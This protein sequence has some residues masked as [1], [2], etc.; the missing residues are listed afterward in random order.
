M[1]RP[2]GA[3]KATST[4]A[5]PAAATVRQL[6]AAIAAC[7]AELEAQRQP[8]AG[9]VGSVLDRLHRTGVD[10]RR[11]AAEREQ[12]GDDVGRTSKAAERILRSLEATAP[13]ET[14]PENRTIPAGEGDAGRVA[15]DGLHDSAERAH[16]RASNLSEELR[17][18]MLAHDVTKSQLPHL[19][20][21]LLR[22]RDDKNG[23]ERELVALRRS[24]SELRRKTRREARRVARLASR[25]GQLQ[26]E[27]FPSVAWRPAGSETAAA[28]P[29]DR[30]PRRPL[31]L[32]L[33]GDIRA[34][35]GI[36]EELRQHA[37]DIADLFDP[38]YYLAQYPDVARAG[39]N[40]LLQYVSQGWQ[41]R[42]RPQLL[43]D[44]DYYEAEAGPITGDPLL[45]Y[46]TRAAGR[47]HPLFDP[48]YYLRTYPDVTQSGVDPLLHY[49]RFGA[50]E[51]RRPSPLFDPEYF[52]AQYDLPVDC[53]DALAAYLTQTDGWTAEPHPL[54]SASWFAARAGIERF[55]EAPLA[56]YQKR[57][58]L[59]A[60]APPHPLV[61]VAR[62]RGQS[63]PLR[64]GRSPLEIF[65]DAD[66][67]SDIDAHILFDARLYRYQVE[68]ER[69]R[70]LDEPPLIDYLK[71]GWR[72]K[73]LLPNVLFDPETYL[74]KNA[75]ESDGPELVHY[76]SEGDRAGLWCH[77]MFNAAVYNR[78]RDDGRPITAL[79]HFLGSPADAAKP[80][81]PHMDR[82]L[83]PRPIEFLRSLADA[84]GELDTAFY[85]ACYPDLRRLGDAAATAHYHGDGRRE[86]RAGSA[87][88]LLQAAG[89][90]VRDVPL[91][92]STAD[93]LH[94]NVGLEELGE[95]FYPLFRHYMAS[96]TKERRWI[97]RWQFH[98]DALPAV[99]AHRPGAARPLDDAAPH[100]DVGVLIH[101]FY[102][103]LW[104]EL[105]GFAANFDAV[106]RDVFVNVV[107]AAWT[108]RL[109]RELR[110]LAPDAFVQLSNDNGRDIGG[111]MRLLDN[112]DFGR[113]E[114]FA[115]MHSKKSPHIAE[116]R[117]AHWR[118]SLLAA[119]A[120]TRERVRACVA[121]FHEDRTIG[122]LGCA[123]YRET[124]MGRNEAAYTAL[125]DRFRIDERYRAPDYLSGTM[126]LIRAPIL[127]RLY[128]EL[129]HAEWEYGG[130]K[131]VEFHMDG[132]LAH[133]VERLIC[134]LVRQMG[135]RIV[136]RP[137]AEER[138]R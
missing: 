120:G 75:V 133:G 8:T 10:I 83:D 98:L 110:E 88:Q 129:Q 14:R 2:D 128:E 35:G 69:G 135:Y 97:G 56:T 15:R 63:A 39:A 42:R 62:L 3:D 67:D 76:L 78:A 53:E 101:L 21:Q 118:R 64:D 20:E 91:G 66:A 136:W 6:R 57:R 95:D 86:G 99:L 25:V 36:S 79:E 123:D 114:L 29:A 124:T 113:Y 11:L 12:I 127:Q 108:P 28:L 138:R 80:S 24:S 26:D 119:F 50:R 52:L 65:C 107:D 104:H 131:D 17:A 96:G 37:A 13:A 106:K 77:P 92:F 87:R 105:S 103:D 81:H 31:V 47:P 74:A 90:R 85:R 68:E 122:L 134:A 130:D 84:S 55:R 132:Q 102:P 59:W 126:F 125:L 94:L 93:Y 61:D 16:R 7:L 19:R 27:R 54:F 117:G 58:D 41:Q 116:E 121:Q 4:A 60:T 51:R 100:V 23:I 9:D 5:P 38:V 89:L 1:I 34:Q 40:P 71:R 46:A 137:I 73:S 45:H 82:P 43:F 111:F 72:D 109:H 18:A 22:L 48:A 30:D 112:I 32:L 115:L 44:P 33:L 49:I 70:R